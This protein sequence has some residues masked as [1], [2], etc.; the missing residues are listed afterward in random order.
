M[1]MIPDKATSESS[2]SVAQ[3]ARYFLWVDTRSGVQKFIMALLL[4]GALLFGL[5]FIVHR[6]VKVPGEQIYGFH[7]IAG[8]VSFTVIVLGARLLRYFIARDESFYAP[9][10]VDCEEYPETGLQKLSHD[11]RIQDS[12][13]TL[14]A[15]ISGKKSI[16]ADSGRHGVS[17]SESGS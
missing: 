13:A 17:R 12:L 2:D 6:H 16:S 15:E 9:N 8:F 5:D 10:G 3:L 1:A 7:A 14:K 11:E 4:L